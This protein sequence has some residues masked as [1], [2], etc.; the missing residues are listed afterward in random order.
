MARFLLALTV[1]LGGT[2]IGVYFLLENPDRFK[3][4]IAQLVSS[5]ADYELQIRGELSWR[6]WPPLAIQAEDVVIYAGGPEEIARFNSMELD[7]DLMPLL[8]QQ[9]IVDVNLLSFEGGTINLIIDE[10]G[11]GNWATP[12]ST[13]KSINR[14]SQNRPP[15]PPAIHQFTANQMT[16]NYDNRQ[17]GDRY[18]LIV[19]SLGTSRLAIDTPFDFS[20]KSKLQGVVDRVSINATGQMTYRAT[21]RIGFEQTVVSGQAS[22]EDQAYPDFR[23]VTSGEWHPDR[24]A[25]VLKQTD[26]NLS[27]LHMI[28]SGIVNLGSSS[29]HFDGILD[30]ESADLEQ[31]TQQFEVTSP[32]TTIQLNTGIFV[33]ADQLNLTDL[34][35][36]FD[37]SEFQG[38]MK[39]IPGTP[40]HLSGDLRLDSLDTSH[41]MTTKPTSNTGPGNPKPGSDS[42][43]IPVSQLQAVNLDVIL[44]TRQFL[45][46]GYKF[47]NGKVEFT[48]DQQVLDLIANAQGLGGR[49]VATTRTKLAQPVTTDIEL[50]IDRL[51]LTSFSG[52]Q[53]VTGT[54][55]GN[56][57]L[58]FLGT[59]LSD[60]NETLVG[61]SAFTVS[62][63]TLDVTPIK[64]IAGT[65]DTLRGKSSRI[66][67][68]PDVM[69]FE[70]MVAQHMFNSGTQSG[71]VFSGQLEN[72]HLT[73]Q[74]GF[75]LIEETLDY[76]VTARFEK[77]EDGSFSVSDQ[78]ADI[79]WPLTCKGNFTD[80]PDELCLGKDDAINDL[81]ADIA[82]QE[83]KRRGNSK[84]EKLI[85][86]KV[87]EE[88]RELTRD[89]FKDLFK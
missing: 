53:G 58:T 1:L 51:N 66:S 59:K 38:R 62:D 85:D 80:T 57:T 19:E 4:Q 12:D 87:P 18:T 68:W 73:A 5:N 50:A 49:L 23:I 43:V 2:A 6:Y 17:S 47:D 3:D 29:P 84:L 42:L 64:R 82:K 33:S 26:I 24:K 46:D 11:T 40:G 88:L 37:A 16:V 56:S 9:R 71:Q 86:E 48:N 20:L 83:L 21:Q 74:G 78:L 41:Y 60:V 72:L 69:A 77:G 8:T 15:E 61:T 14:S 25:I 35:G 81:V 67:S 79:R 44:R 55:T 7:V 31:F 30:L 28:I 75:N 52:M 89:L 45:Y 63:G 39:Y 65:I 10:S 36:Q 70:H 76:D 54:L 13:N 34:K 32:V 22:I 27:T